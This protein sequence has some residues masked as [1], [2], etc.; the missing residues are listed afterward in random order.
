MSRAGRVQGD[1]PLTP[2]ETRRAMNLNIV[3]GSMGTM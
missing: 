2:A 3:L 1:T